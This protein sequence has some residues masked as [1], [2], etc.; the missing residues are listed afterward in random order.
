MATQLDRWL[1]TGAEEPILE[2][3]LPILD[4]H[5]HL[6]DF[7]DPSPGRLRG[8]PEGFFKLAQSRFGRVVLQYM[9]ARRDPVFIGMARHFGEHT[10]GWGHLLDKWMLPE[11]SASACTGH[12][13]VR[14][15]VFIECGCETQPR[16]NAARS[17]SAP[18]ELSPDRT[19]PYHHRS[20][21]LAHARDP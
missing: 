8:M 17:N 4:P 15:F 13:D 10:R 14:G 2:P 11:L 12:H 20:L 19:Q 21:S 3:D 6:W 9:M 18:I 1:A 7:Q 5:I 16:S